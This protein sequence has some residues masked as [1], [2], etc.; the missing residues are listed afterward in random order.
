MNPKTKEFWLQVKK[1]YHKSNTVYMCDASPTFYKQWSLICKHHIKEQ[2]CQFLQIHPLFRLGTL[3]HLF[4]P[5]T[6]LHPY[7]EIE[8][9]KQFI[10][11]M[12]NISQ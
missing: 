10:N 12:I 7:H 3:N 6:E 2:A 4:K 1:E 5:Y 8:I 9:R 11:H